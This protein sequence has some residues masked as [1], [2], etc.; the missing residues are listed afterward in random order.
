MNE[1]YV[2][3]VEPVPIREQAEIVIVGNGIAGLSAALEACRLSPETHVTIITEQSYPTIYTPALKQFATGKI[4][5]EQLIAQPAGSEYMHRVHVV[6][7]HV[8]QI[9]TR[10]R[11]LLLRDGRTIGYQ[12]LLLSTGSIPRG[13]PQ[14]LPGRDL[15]GVMTLHRLN[16]YIDLRRRLSEVK[17]AVVIGSGAHAIETVMG[18]LERRVQVYWLLRREMCMSQVLDA[19]ASAEILEDCRRAG[20]KIF[21]NCEVAEIVG[22]V[23]VVTGVVT[24]DKRMIACQLVIACTGSSP[25]TALAS[26]S[27]VLIRCKKGIRADEYLRTNVRHVF[28]AGD[29]AEVEDSVSGLYQS[30]MLWHVAV[31]QGQIAAAVMSGQSDSIQVPGSSW[32]ATQLGSLHMVTVGEPLSTARGVTILSDHTKKSY[33]RLAFFDNRLIGYLSVGNPK[34]D[35]FSIKRL[36]D[37][38]HSVRGFEKDLLMGMFDGRKYFSQS[39][40][41]P[42]ASKS[43]M[44]ELP[45]L[46]QS[47]KRQ[48]VRSTEPMLPVPPVIASHAV[49]KTRP[50]QME[51]LEEQLS[52]REELQ[53]VPTASSETVLAVEK[54][55]DNVTTPPRWLIPAILPT[56]LLLTADTQQIG[57]SWLNLALALTI[58]GQAP[59]PTDRQDVALGDVLYLALEENELQLRE[60]IESVL[61][62][63]ETLS[64]AITCATRWEHL[65]TEGL[66]ALEQWL[67]THQQARLIIIDSWRKIKPLPQVSSDE[68]AIQGLKHL[69]DMY[70][71][72][73]LLVSHST[74]TQ[75]WKTSQQ[76]AEHAGN[77]SLIDGWLTLKQGEQARQVILAGIGR[78]FTANMQFSV[79]FHSGSCS[80][81]QVVEKKRSARKQTSAKKVRQQTKIV[82]ERSL[83][84]RE[85]MPLP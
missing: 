79:A 30:K 71:I 58:S 65:H 81:T 38:G 17:Q 60:R 49:R 20:A 78:A 43:T 12:S 25:Q 15:D 23:G 11:F 9:Y 8:E 34:P 64:S 45:A 83:S 50:L 24:N 42:L 27:D 14:S 37:E 21:L 46:M 54:S 70:D 41:R 7:G 26:C 47:L 4:A 39:A 10:E 3:A 52:Q 1:Q 18:L 77:G 61:P 84:L 36:I 82:E 59:A 16:D 35:T 69:A 22:K 66:A 33:R 80:I 51:E 29:C 74:R 76:T 53:E 44:G 73:I 6:S 5:R 72:A 32:Q 62:P 28:A 13:L 55:R 67:Q 75:L 68:E 57:L 48:I 56:G 40:A 85:S 31:T 63:G 2:S 19:E